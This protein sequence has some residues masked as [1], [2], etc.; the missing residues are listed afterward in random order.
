MTV[1]VSIQEITLSA[2]STLGRVGSIAGLTV[3]IKIGTGSTVVVGQ[4]IAIGTGLAAVVRV[5]GK[6]VVA[7]A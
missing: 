7:V 3:G 5:A 6:V 2:L 4:E 1:L